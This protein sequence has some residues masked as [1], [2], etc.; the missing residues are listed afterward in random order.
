MACLDFDLELKAI[1]VSWIGF[2]LISRSSII[3]ATSISDWDS[4]TAPDN[5]TGIGDR[6]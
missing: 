2:L 4:T 6:R 3:S 5:D 1:E